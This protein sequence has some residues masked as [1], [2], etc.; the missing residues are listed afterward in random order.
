MNP[1]EN[2][3]ARV[4]A[5]GDEAF[6]RRKN[7]RKKLRVLV[8]IAALAVLAFALYSLFYSLNRGIFTE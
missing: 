4:L 5:L 8:E 1:K 3:D 6:S 7:R 2:T